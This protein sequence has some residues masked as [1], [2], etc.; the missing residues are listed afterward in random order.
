MPNNNERDH[1]GQPSGT[2]PQP[3][4]DPSVRDH[5]GQPTGVSP[6]PS[7]PPGG[8]GGFGT[9]DGAE[10]RD[11]R[12]ESTGV[13]RD[14]RTS[15][16]KHVFVLMLENRSFDHLL[17]FSGI[18][19]TDAETGKP[20]S[21]DGLKGN[22]TQ[23]YKS[24]VPGDAGPVRDHRTQTFTV[25]LGA[26]DR[27]PS[28]KGPGHDFKDALKQ[29]CGE[30]ATYPLK[31]E[32]GGGP[33]PP[34]NNSGFVA[35]YAEVAPED[36]GAALKCFGPPPS[37]GKATAPDQVP[38]LTALAREFLVCDRWFS[39]MPGPT[40]PN[41]FFVHA[42]ECGNFDDSPDSDDIIWASL[43]DGFEF[44]HGT[45]FQKMRDAGVP[46]RIYAG[47]DFPNVGELDGIS[48]VWDVD[49]YED[50]AEDVT[51]G[52]YD[53]A[54]TFIEPAYD[55]VN[56]G[57][58]YEGGNS[59][60]PCGSVAAGEQLIKDTYEALRRSP[61]WNESM[62]V[63][64]WDEHGGFY[65]HVAPPAVHPTGSVG[66]NHHFTFDRLGVRVPAVIASPLI[67]KNRVC[68][69]V[70]EHC[71]IPA[72]LERMFH[73]APFG[74]RVS[75]S[76][77]INDLASLPTARTDAPMT[78]PDV[79]PGSAPTRRARIPL[80]AS[81]AQAPNASLTSGP[82][83]NITWVLRAVVAQ[84]LKLAAPSERQAILARAGT[85]KSHGDLLAYQK[86]VHALVVAQ[87]AKFN[88]TRS[89]KVR[90]MAKA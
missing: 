4:S 87:R 72:T 14:H 3:T 26:D 7:S 52:D 22:E 74:E 34:V 35:S 19:G 46:F 54:Y 69:R 60:H 2:P 16:V 41:R 17:G 36:P 77:G 6:P 10:V 47:D 30:H 51:S 57:S 73:L 50:F 48:L 38:V 81:V 64:L 86:E 21:I 67:P 40:E 79:A 83:G 80:A 25:S 18:T 59:Q 45:V 65:D 33:Y 61:I 89:S 84:H 82:T 23:Q 71:T 43:V 78:L 58:K 27:M 70:L 90:V 28:G 76:S 37:G 39:S 66:K 55:V 42:G 29:L 62:L 8:G 63:V 12:G 53:A 20:T 32:H 68:H 9:L 88:I 11:H 44:N 15:P 49:D 31:D 75:L 56:L 24:A 85:L 5:R 1:R 13:V